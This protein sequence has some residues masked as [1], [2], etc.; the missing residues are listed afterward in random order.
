MD[1]FDQHCLHCVL[2]N[3]IAR[4]LA[5]H[6]NTGAQETVID[7]ISVL[8]EVVCTAVVN[9]TE[10]E[11]TQQVILERMHNIV[12]NVLPAQIES[13]LLEFRVAAAERRSKLL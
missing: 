11:P 1:I 12:N 10:D 3:Q 2:T 6:P 9:T 4:F 8:T 5:C 13:A 7:V